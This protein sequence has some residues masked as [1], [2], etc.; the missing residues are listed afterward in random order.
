MSDARDIFSLPVYGLD[1]AAKDAIFLREMF[2]LTRHHAA[3]SAEYGRIVAGSGSLNQ[4]F[5]RIEDTP[6][7]HVRLFKNYRL[8]SIPD[9]RIVKTITSSGTTGQNVSRIFLDDETSRNQT[10]ALVYILQSFLGKQRL[11]MLIIDHPSVIK[12]RKSFSARGA[13]I[14]GLS[15]FG[16]NHTY[17]LNDDMSLNLPAI[18]DF[19]ER[20]GGQRV[21]IFGFTFMIWQYLVSPW[22][23]AEIISLPEGFLFHSGGWK[24]LQDQAVS[25]VVFRGRIEATL[26]SKHVHNFYGM[27]EQVGSVFVECDEGFLHAPLTA[28]IVV[29]RPE[30]L[31]PQ[32]FG[33]SGIIQVLS[34]L[35]RSYPG[36]SI[37]TE[38]VG[39]IHGLDDCKCGRKGHY[40]SVQGRLAKAEAR[41][42]SDTFSKV[43]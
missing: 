18:R 43:S 36:H 9:E 21:L 1:K 32:P 6:F 4:P 2:E 8:S 22:P 16:R 17:A 41:G 24:K 5:S 11:P 29:R 3:S 20:F 34:T 7:L 26:G 14:L 33:E 19:A 35:P 12:D 38:D 28:D 15:N 42:C 10:K 37:L 39:T 13:G 27:A 31:Q 40:F 30:T 23:A 25:N